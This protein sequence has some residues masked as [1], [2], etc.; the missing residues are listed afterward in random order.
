MLKDEKT[1]ER[2]DETDKPTVSLLIP[3]YNEEKQIDNTLKTVLPIMDSLDLP[4]EI[5][6]VDDG[7]S[8]RSWELLSGYAEK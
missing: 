5:V 8:D 3:F 2:F 1:A 4:Y 7:S 6:C